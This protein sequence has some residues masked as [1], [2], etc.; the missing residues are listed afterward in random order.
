MT[1]P[2]KDFI[3]LGST[4]LDIAFIKFSS[5]YLSWSDASFFFQTCTFSPLLQSYILQ[6]MNS[7]PD[8]VCEKT[9]MF[10][11][12]SHDFLS[13]LPRCMNYCRWRPK[14]SL[15]LRYFALWEYQV[16]IRRYF[17]FPGLNFFYSNLNFVYHGE[18]S[19]WTFIYF[20]ICLYKYKRKRKICK[21]R[22]FILHE[23]DFY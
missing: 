17:K 23:K 16:Y 20:C 12:F 18:S 4:R 1:G 19:L 6:V 8:W 22:G 21:Q 7:H 10:S 15:C 14:M 13:Q 5:K 3:Q 2:R 9:E 11:P